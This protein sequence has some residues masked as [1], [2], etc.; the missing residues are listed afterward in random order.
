MASSRPL[1]RWPLLDRMYAS[2]WST[3]V[4]LALV[5]ISVLF[6]VVFPRIANR[7]I[8]KLRDEIVELSGPARTAAGAVERASPSR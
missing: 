6:L 1:L 7:R 5:M 4:A 2:N 3:P 8:E